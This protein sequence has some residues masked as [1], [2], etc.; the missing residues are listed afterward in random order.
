MAACTWRVTT[1]DTGATPN[2]SGA[3]TPAQDDLL[4]VIV[5]AAAS[6]SG[7]A[8]VPTASANGI[9]FVKALQMTY[10][11]GANSLDI[12]I[13]EQLVPASPVS[14]TVS[15]APAD[16]ATGT[17]IDVVSVSGMS[18]TGTSAIRQTG[19]GFGGATTTPSVGFGAACLT[20][21]P[22][23]LAVANGT[24]PVGTST[25]TNWIS[26]NSTVAY[27]T[28]TTGYQGCRR[29]SGFTGS[30]VS[31][32]S[33]SASIWGA[34]GIELDASAASQNLSTTAALS[35]AGTLTTPS[36]TPATAQ[37]AALS[38][39]GTLSA[40]GAQGGGG[41]TAAPTLVATVES[42][43]NVTTSPKT[44]AALNVLAGDV[45][46]DVAG[47]EGISSVSDD[48]TI[49]NSGAAQTWTERQIVTTVVGASSFA[50]ATTA[51][52]AAD[53]AAET[54]SC[55]YNVATY[56]F[57]HRVFQ[58]R[59]S[60]GIGASTKASV[61]GAAATGTISLTTTQDKSAIVVLLIDFNAADGASRT[62]ATVNG[63]TPTAGN[64]F[65]KTYQ[66]LPPYYTVYA[67]YYPDVGAAGAKTVGLAS[68]ST[69]YSIVAIEVKGAAGSG[70]NFSGTAAMSGAGTL[71]TTQT[72]ATGQTAALSGSGTLSLVQ[73]QVAIGIAAAL[74][75]SGT[76][77]TTR[78]VAVG[79]TAA[80]SGTG[81]LTTTQL[82]AT[83]QTAALSGGGTLTASGA[84]GGFATTAALSGGGTL[85]TTQV[86]AMGQTA[87][88]SGSGTLTTSQQTPAIGQTATLS[89]AGTLSTTR[90]VA[91]GTTAALSG[92]GTL[93][94]TTGQTATRTA[95]LS[96]SGT[97][98]ATPTGVSVAGAA[99]LSGVGTLTVVAN[100]AVTR[101]ATL[102]GGGTLSVV[103]NAARTTIASFGGAGTLSIPAQQPAIGAT[104]VLSGSGS[105][106]ASGYAP[107]QAVL[108]R[109]WGIP[110]KNR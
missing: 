17:V 1:A 57:G 101:Q 63:I 39:A 43:W 41:G 89:G 24:N 6:V 33:T 59:G 83:G 13:A 38:G 21:N 40:S 98:A 91:V 75:G 95:A 11:S 85:S 81:A 96:G 49:T 10:A 109:G 7:A 44:N 4:V 90:T 70:S 94:A 16:A 88:L 2:A 30:S 48:M 67:A 58:F 8:E 65:E 60:D 31:W 27:S 77:S 107:G 15:W 47:S 37:T 105:I 56:R 104:A 5:Q 100:V 12:Y 64:G 52:Q 92:T 19:S 80:L 26:I 97:L 46:V 102:S 32:N 9:T 73:N 28:P 99:S 78:A 110:L 103:T 18:R 20:G 72:P 66:A 25:P 53:N 108:L 87:A 35:G 86:P 79:Q 14:M 61:S 45:L 3:F 54:V 84:Q 23:I 42:A 51:T 50:Q 55:A 68:P 36:Q 69:I 29:D 71:T 93:T 76:L 74:S 62:W 34:V 106:G 82:P 22:V